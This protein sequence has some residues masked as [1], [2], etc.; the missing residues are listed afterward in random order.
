LLGYIGFSIISEI[1]AICSYSKKV[2][3]PAANVYLLSMTISGILNKT[4][5]VALA[6]S[7]S[8]AENAHQAVVYITWIF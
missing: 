8:F 2:D 6:Y 7:G 3:V 5:L 4:M 1:V